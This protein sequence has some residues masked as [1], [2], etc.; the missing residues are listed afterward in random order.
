MPS[1]TTSIK[2]QPNILAQE[3]G[4]EIV[5]LNMDNEHYYTLKKSGVRMWQL[6]GQ[7]SDVEVTKKQLLEEYEVDEVTI[8]RDLEGFVSWLVEKELA[9][10]NTAE[11]SQNA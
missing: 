1:K 2:I 7:H 8:Q 6:L 3:L 4:E 10:V 9:I 5:L 11:L